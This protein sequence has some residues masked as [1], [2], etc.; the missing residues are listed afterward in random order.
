M[1]PKLIYLLV[2]DDELQISRWVKNALTEKD[3]E[4][5]ILSMNIFRGN[6]AATTKAEVQSN[7][8]A[9]PFLSQFRYVALDQIFSSGSG[10]YNLSNEAGKNGFIHLLEKTSPATIV[11]LSDSETDLND[12]RSPGFK[13]GF[14]KSLL[15]T[16]GLKENITFKEIMLPKKPADQARWVEKE[17]KKLGVEISTKTAFALLD[18]IEVFDPRVISGELSKLAA[19]INFEG[20]ITEED[21]DSAGIRIFSADIFELTGAI[22]LKEKLRASR[23][24]QKL[25]LDREP[26]EVFQMIIRQF[27]M[28]L[29][30][31]DANVNGVPLSELAVFQDLRNEWVRSKAQEQAIKFELADLKQIYKR[32]LAIDQAVKSSLI[33]LPTATDMLIAEVS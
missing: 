22:G 20:K 23:T 14:I 16:P 29:A 1:A 19:Y 27:R 28:I 30:V 15:N 8:Q 18:R 4:S 31:K 6:M 3:T 13:S 17:A 7:L 32:L 12:K 24:Y 9:M 10:G 5:S 21:L 2:G 25:L 33:E 11:V 26:E